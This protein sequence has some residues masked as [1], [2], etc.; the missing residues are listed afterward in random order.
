MD[1]HAIIIADRTGVIQFWSPGAAKLI[2]HSPQEAVGQK[3]DLVVPQALR[4]QHWH[5][6]HK[7]MATGVA[8]IPAGEFFDLPIQTRNGE[9]T[10]RGQLHVL[11]DEDKS[12]IGAMAIFTL[13]A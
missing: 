5:G 10:F 7:A 11:R 6:F 8:G 9:K 2:G 13:P 12:A 1:N 4:E 3:L